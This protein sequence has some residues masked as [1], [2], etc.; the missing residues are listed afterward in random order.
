MLPGYENV[1]GV[2][3]QV[4][5][6]WGVGGRNP[7]CVIETNAGINA[8][9]LSS[10]KFPAWL[11]VGECSVTSFNFVVTIKGYRHLD[12]NPMNANRGN[13]NSST[14][15]S[16]YSCVNSQADTCYLRYRAHIPTCL[17]SLLSLY[18]HIDY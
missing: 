4:K 17:F 10:E 3:G 9:I 14:H 8:F 16:C 7:Q 12:C 15:I 1:R 11:N 13:S 5:E 18:A 6:R 2:V